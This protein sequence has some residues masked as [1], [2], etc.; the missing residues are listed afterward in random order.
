MIE[1]EP[2]AFGTSYPNHG[3]LMC[4]EDGRRFVRM[5]LVKKGG[6][7]I[8]DLCDRRRVRARAG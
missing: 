7:D 6:R 8:H 3:M 2:E 5:G 4:F 1:G